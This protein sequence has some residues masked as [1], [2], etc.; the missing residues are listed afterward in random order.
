MKSRYKTDVAVDNSTPVPR[1]RYGYTRC[2]ARCRKEDVR[3]LTLMGIN[4]ELRE[5]MFRY[6]LHIGHAFIARSDKVF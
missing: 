3:A 2:G 5:L 6:I 1:T 4:N